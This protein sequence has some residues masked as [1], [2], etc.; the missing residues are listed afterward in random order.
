MD[1]DKGK[2]TSP[3]YLLLK[4]LYRPEQIERMSA[5]ADGFG[6][7]NQYN[8]REKYLPKLVGQDLQVGILYTLER[9]FCDSWFRLAIATGVRV[10]TYQVDQH[11]IHWPL[12]MPQ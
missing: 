2:Q 11:R 7:P 3:T 6:S 1:V 5:A 9:H 4:L 12:V 8:Y 10:E